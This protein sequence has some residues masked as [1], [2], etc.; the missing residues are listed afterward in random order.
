MIIMKAHRKAAPILFGFLCGL[1]GE[2]FL[3]LQGHCAAIEQRLYSDFKLIAFLSAPVDGKLRQS[4][5]DG[6][7]A[8]D[9]VESVAYV[10]ADEALGRLV[11]A[12]PG[13]AQVRLRQD[14]L[15]GALEIRLRPA[16][17]GRLAEW[18][19]R[20]E[21]VKGIEEVRFKPL[22][23]NALL[24]VRFYERFLG[25]LTGLAWFSAAAFAAAL[26]WIKV[27]SRSWP[28]R[29]AIEPAV[30][31]CVGSLAGAAACL[32]LAFPMRSVVPLWAAPAGWGQLGLILTGGVI[33]WAA[34]DS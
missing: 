10:G 2:G 3:F 27:R 20:A 9:G 28:G 25:V 11:K 19:V 32:A 1:G 31:G 30:S 26:L 12:Q 33:G 18:V 4:I 7:S 13:L 15:P 6:V 23:A 17:L 5:I 8:L 14:I 24:Q 29:A 34:G 22:E 21:A 16:M